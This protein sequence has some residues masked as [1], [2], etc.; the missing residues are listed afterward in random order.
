M[1]RARSKGRTRLLLEESMAS[2]QWTPDL[3]PPVKV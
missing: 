1:C 3:G 2:L